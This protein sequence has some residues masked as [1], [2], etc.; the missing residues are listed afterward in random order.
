MCWRFAVNGAGLAMSTMDIIKLHGGSPANFLDVGG[1]ATTSQVSTAFELIT[2]DKQ[3]RQPVQYCT[4]VH[5]H[6][7][8]QRQQ[9]LSGHVY[10][11]RLLR[12]RPSSSTS[13]AASCVVTSSHR[14]S[15]KR[16]SSFP[17]RFPWSCDCKVRAFTQCEQTFVFEARTEHA[18]SDVAGTK[19]NEAKELIRKSGLASSLISI[20]DLDE[21]AKKVR[22]TSHCSS[23]K[24]SCCPP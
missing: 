24:N 1:A 8:L 20:D 10:T 12:S 23:S 13:S 7:L 18:S 22:D 3:V 15:S 5:A 16:R 11:C 2:S 6:V 14:E 17:S 4:C 21:A 19:V 9:L